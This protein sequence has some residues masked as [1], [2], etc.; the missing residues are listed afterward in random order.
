MGGV[1]VGVSSLSVGMDIS[2]QELKSIGSNVCVGGVN[3]FAKNPPFAPDEFKFQV[4]TVVSFS[5]TFGSATAVF[6]E[7]LTLLPSFL[8]PGLQQA[9]TATYLG[10][11][12]RFQVDI[13]G[14]G[15]S[16]S[17]GTIADFS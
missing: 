11:I 7:P 8:P 4:T 5:A 12:A 3:L 1:G 14:V 13:P 6:F 10:G 9:L 15:V 2:F 17:V 16:V